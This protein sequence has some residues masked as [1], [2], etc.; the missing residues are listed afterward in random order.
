MELKEELTKGDIQSIMRM[1]K[2]LNDVSN[3][4]K[5]YHFAIVDQLEGVAE[6]AK[7]QEIL[8][9]HEIKVMEL[10]DRIAELVKEPLEE[11]RDAESE[12]GT[13]KASE[14]P[15][16]SKVGWWIDSWVS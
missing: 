9:G 13:P 7:E 1:S 10:I 15:P 4:F 2:L 3:D 8:N 16:L 11:K 14:H 5:I 6:E 12:F